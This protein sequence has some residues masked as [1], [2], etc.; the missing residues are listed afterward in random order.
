MR[1]KYYGYRAAQWLSTRLPPAAAFQ[2]AQRVADAYWQG[3]SAAKDRAIVRQN[4]STIT[5]EPVPT[6]A[7][8]VRDVFRHFA[9]YVVEFF[10]IHQVPRP[11]V[12]VEGKEHLDHVQR[13]RRGTILLTAHLGNWEVGAILLR[14]MGYPVSAVALTHEDPRMNRLFDAQRQRC[15]I[16]VIPLGPRAAVRSLQRLHAGECLGVLGD[17]VFSDTGLLVPWFGRPAWLPRG[18]AILSLRSRAPMVP[19]FL[20]RE[21][22]WQFRFCFEPPIDP[23]SRAEGEPTVQRLTEAYARVLERRLRRHPEQWLMF[24]PLGAR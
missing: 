15:G 10:T 23:G 16:E 17:R 4:L 12:I 1:L 5:G 7:P 14:R 19:T 11:E 13:Q 24:Q 6:D 21:G 22:P 18:P 20:I 3:A 9:R 8:M 2:W